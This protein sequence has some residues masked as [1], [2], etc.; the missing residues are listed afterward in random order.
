MQGLC[1]W[2]FRTGAGL[3]VQLVLPIS[4]LVQP[5]P[6]TVRSTGLLQPAGIE[7]MVSG[8]A[9]QDHCVGLSCSG[10]L[11]TPLRLRLIVGIQTKMAS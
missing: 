9:W 6:C 4:M 11:V 2:I 1:P 8:L 5:T 3:I 7:M 10:S